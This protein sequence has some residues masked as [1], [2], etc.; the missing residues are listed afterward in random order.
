MP[1]L[2]IVSDNALE[3]AASLT[4]SSTAGAL[5]ASN[6]VNWKK[7]AFWRA[8]GT[9]ARITAL[10]ATPEPI[11]F[12]GFAF[13]NWSPT[14]M[15]RVRVS[16]EAAATNLVRYS[17]DFANGAWSKPSITLTANYGPAPDGSNT[18]CRVQFTG[19]GQAV[20]QA[21][22]LGAGVLC[23]GSIWVRGTA[24]QTIAVSAGGVDQVF[25]LSGAWQRLKA[26]GKVSSNN[27]FAVSTGSGTNA[28]DIQ[29][30]GAQLE[31]GGTC[32]S[33]YPTGASAATRPAGYIDTWQSYDYDSG[34]APACPWPATKLR[35]FTA[36]QAASAY[37]Y[38]GGT[39]ARHWLPA[40]MQARGL[41]VDINDPDNVQ[42]YLEACSMVAGPYWS[43]KYNAASAAVTVL[44]GSE[45]LQTGGGD[46]CGKVGFI[47]DEVSI[48]LSYFEADDRAALTAMARNSAVYPLLLS[49]F[50]ND[51]DP[52]RERD[53]MVY[54]T[55]SKSSAIG[56]KYAAGYTTS[57]TFKEV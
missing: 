35:G 40:E 18:A 36:A 30:W 33:Y 52:A 54:A 55:R 12:A 26:V 6:L 25:T 51:P 44:D 27:I 15:M 28:R 53:Y 13:C 38:G 11:Q 37:A 23:S 22:G 46:T 8:T 29:I 47:S 20:S 49:V 4:A 21:A 19:A 50:P 48:D 17:S 5:A 1:N 10:F 7:S 2:R 34:W 56:M 45:N 24:S 3:R 14:V 41:A 16:E 31:T 32:T 39:Y 43:P 57:I 42:G 9:S